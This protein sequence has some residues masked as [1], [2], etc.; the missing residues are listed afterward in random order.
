MG[1]DDELAP[2]EQILKP[3]VLKGNYPNP[4]NPSTTI[5]FEVKKAINKMVQIRI[6]NLKGQLIKVLA[7]QINRS[8]NYEIVWD[9]T[10]NLG[11][12]VSSGTYYYVIDFGDAQLTGKM[13][14]I[15]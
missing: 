3:Y 6:F 8:G 9:G 7:L 15:K 14:M 4:F 11:L 5:R 2:D 10:D 12:T 13:S 1:N